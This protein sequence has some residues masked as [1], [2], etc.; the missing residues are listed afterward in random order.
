MK[1]KL[2]SVIAG[3]TLLGVS[4]AAATVFEID[5]TVPGGGGMFGPLA[6]SGTITT[7]GE[8]SSPL[9]DSDILS[10]SITLTDEDLTSVYTTIS[11]NSGPTGTGG[12]ISGNGLTETSRFLI[13]NYSSSTS[14]FA[15][16]N[17]VG[18]LGSVPPPN[19]TVGFE[20]S[21]FYASLFFN[22]SPYA[23]QGQITPLSGKL[24]IGVSESFLASRGPRLTVCTNE[25]GFFDTPATPLPAA[26]PLFATGLGAIGLLGWRRKRKA[27]AAVAAA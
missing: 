26:F 2:L 3:V 11:L 16:L 17:D 10:Y 5:T 15:L 13:Y 27:Q 21:E 23:D 18:A 25:C 12:G 7:N 20:P 19:G 14:G 6:V 22:T 24:I 4:Q 1:A 9:V 8:T